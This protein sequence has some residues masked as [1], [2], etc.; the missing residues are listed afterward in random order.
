MAT[1]QSDDI[2]QQLRTIT[3]G[4]SKDQILKLNMCRAAYQDISRKETPTIFFLGEHFCNV[5]SMLPGKWEKWVRLTCDGITKRTLTNYMAVWSEFSPMRPRIEKSG[6]RPAH[7]Y[8]LAGATRDVVEEVLTRAERDVRVTTADIKKLNPK[9]KGNA[10]NKADKS[11]RSVAD[12]ARS[13]AIAE[14][15]A[16]LVPKLSRIIESAVGNAIDVSVFLSQPI[17][18]IPKE[19]LKRS[20]NDLD[21]AVQRLAA[22]NGITSTV[23]L[24]DT[25]I[26]NWKEALVPL[27]T[28][29]EDPSDT[30]VK[31][32]ARDVIGFLLA[33]GTT[34][35]S[36]SKNA[37]RPQSRDQVD[38]AA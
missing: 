25:L 28:L 19:T 33:G 17:G 29:L 8:A 10:N 13:A 34:S 37:R 22:L 9:A 23:E 20:V 21:C 3:K 11:S 7:L 6:L 31:D 35:R 12:D 26:D 16:A 14:F 38:V 32:C 18:S 24:A 4:L 15:S 1:R 5:K 2:E 30:N 36:S 27:R